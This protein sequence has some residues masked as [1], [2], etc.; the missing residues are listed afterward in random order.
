LWPVFTVRIVVPDPPDVKV[1]VELLREAWI[2]DEE[3]VTDRVMVPLKPWRLVR[4]IVLVFDELRVRLRDDGFA[5]IE[6]SPADVTVS[7]RLVE[8]DNVPPDPVTVSV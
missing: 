8:C 1:T 4:V 3:S 6:K 5:D 7:E 2:F